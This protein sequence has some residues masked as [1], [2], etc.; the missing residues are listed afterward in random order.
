MLTSIA[1]VVC[2]STIVETQPFCFISYL[3]FLPAKKALLKPSQ[4]PVEGVLVMRD[5]VR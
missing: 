3:D 4:Y 2:L 1:I 5:K